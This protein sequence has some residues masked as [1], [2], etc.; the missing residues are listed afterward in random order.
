MTLSLMSSHLLLVHPPPKKF[1]RNIWKWLQ[2]IDNYLN[3]L[4]L[5]LYFHTS[6]FHFFWRERKKR[7]LLVSLC[8]VLYSLCRI[9]AT[10][11]S[12][13]KIP[14]LKKRTQNWFLHIHFFF[15]CPPPLCRHP[16]P[17]CLLLKLPVLVT[18]IQSKQRCQ[19]LPLVCCSPRLPGLVH[20]GSMPS[21]FPYFQHGGMSKVTWVPQTLCCFPEWTLLLS[22]LSDGNK[23][24]INV[25]WLLIG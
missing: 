10:S 18:W 23:S 7:I 14:L 21:V 16:A 20:F 9:P 4:L 15:F 11:C 1:F 13:L 5:L 24:V 19:S 17:L 3:H 22:V 12:L 2:N 6:S 8:S 25:T